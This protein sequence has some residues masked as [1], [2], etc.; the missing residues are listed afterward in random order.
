MIISNKLI[1]VNLKEILTLCLA[2]YGALL[3]TGLLV[4]TLMK[5]R[6]RLIVLARYS[7]DG[8]GG[9][10]ISVQVS[11]AGTRPITVNRP[12]LMTGDGR[13][14]VVVGPD[15]K[16]F[17]ITLTEGQSAQALM[18]LERAGAA[19][20]GSGIS[21]VFTAVVKDQLGRK[22]KAKDPIAVV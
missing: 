3:S 21:P 19:V 2:I 7:L 15:P 20:L 9:R 22:Y 11:N 16:P 1:K 12:Y 18:D 6:K 13:Q 14:L 17:P 4:R 5:D 10:Y 8:T